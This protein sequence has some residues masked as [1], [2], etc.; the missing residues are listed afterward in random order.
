MLC[1][2]DI[3]FVPKLPNKKQI[4]FGNDKETRVEHPTFACADGGQLTT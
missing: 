1:C 4:P 3:I 2:A